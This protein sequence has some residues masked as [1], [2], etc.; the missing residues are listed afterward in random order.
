MSGKIIQSKVDTFFLEEICP[1]CNSGKIS[2]SPNS[3]VYLTDPPQLDVMCNNNDCEYVSTRFEKELYPQVRYE[4]QPKEIETSKFDETKLDDNQLAFIN[5]FLRNQLYIEINLKNNTSSQFK[6]DLDTLDIILQQLYNIDDYEKLS[7]KDWNSYSATIFHIYH[8]EE[9]YIMIPKKE[10]DEI[11]DIYCADLNLVGIWFMNNIYELKIEYYTNYLDFN[12]PENINIDNYNSEQLSFIE[13]FLN[14]KISIEFNQY[15]KGNNLLINFLND[16]YNIDDSLKFF[17]IFKYESNKE[18]KL[19]ICNNPLSNNK[20]YI[21]INDYSLISQEYKSNDILTL[22]KFNILFVNKNGTLKDLKDK[23]FLN[24]IT[25]DDAITIISTG[26]PLFF[27]TNSKSWYLE[28]ELDLG[29]PAISFR[30]KRKDF[31]FTFYKDKISIYEENPNDEEVLNNIM[32][33]LTD[34]NHVCYVQAYLC[35]YY[36]EAINKMIYNERD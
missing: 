20:E 32:D 27:E 9:D 24:E 12:F 17:D 19:Y 23:K 15:I 1:I 5:Q 10:I 11:N 26:Y 28:H 34:V 3:K 7:E 13:K 31:H 25:L 2:K 4:Y 21:I 8:N 22:E 14:D 30:N 6:D 36:I 35:G 18:E 16:I 29:E 33:T